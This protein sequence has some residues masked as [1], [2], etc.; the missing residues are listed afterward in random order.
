M[1][2]VE[3]SSRAAQPLEVDGKTVSPSTKEKK[4]PQE[5]NSGKSAHIKA[6]QNA[7]KKECII[8]KIQ[9]LQEEKD[10]VQESGEALERASAGV[11]GMR[12]RFG[13]AKVAGKAVED[14][15]DM[16]PADEFAEIEAELETH[17]SGVPKDGPLAHHSPRK[18]LPTPASTHGDVSASTTKASSVSDATLATPAAD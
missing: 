5:Q 8:H 12:Q 10:S 2:C 11:A 6:F 1:S 9:V 17:T 13:R 18:L 7:V 14:P 3:A 4:E 15:L 16:V